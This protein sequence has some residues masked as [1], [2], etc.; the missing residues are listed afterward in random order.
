MLIKLIKI[1]WWFGFVGFT[2]Y[3][4]IFNVNLGEKD[5][6]HEKIHLE[7]QR[8]WY[9][10][11][12]YFGVALWLG[13]YLLALPIGYNPFRWKWEYEAYSK[14]QE[15]KDTII[16]KILKNSYLLWWNN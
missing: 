13:L 9:Q 8:K 7:Q 5:L 11:G 15:Y 3:P 4:Y 6:K 12:W 1:K 10:T 16:K 14:G 2:I